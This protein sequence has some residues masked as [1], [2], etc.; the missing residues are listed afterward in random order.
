M[1]NKGYFDP[2]GIAL[3]ND[4]V[5]ANFIAGKYA[6]YQNGSWNCGEIGSRPSSPSRSLC[7]P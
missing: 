3:G 5:K 1:I 7:S 4:E 2:N 6:F